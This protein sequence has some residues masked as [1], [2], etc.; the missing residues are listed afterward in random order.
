MACWCIYSSPKWAAFLEGITAV[1][2]N[3]QGYSGTG[4]ELRARRT[5][6]LYPPGTRAALVE[7]SINFPTWFPRNIDEWN[8]GD[9]PGREVCPI[10]EGS[11][12]IGNHADEITVNCTS[13]ISRCTLMHAIAMDTALIPHPRHSRTSLVPSM[14]STYAR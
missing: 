8:S 13:P 11:F 5:W 2:L 4:Y 14:L 12:I 7:K 6:P 9:W 10:K 1:L 3:S